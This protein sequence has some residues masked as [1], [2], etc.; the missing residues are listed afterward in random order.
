MG[1]ASGG[2]SGRLGAAARRVAAGRPAR[3]ASAGRIAAGRGPADE[4]DGVV[5]GDGA[6][7]LGQRRPGRAREASRWAPPGGV[8]TTTRLADG[9][10]GQSASS[11]AAGPSRAGRG[12]RGTARRRQ[13]RPVGERVDQRPSAART[14]R[15]PSS[16]RSRDS[17]AWVTTTPSSASS[18]ASSACERTAR[19]ARISPTRA[20]RA[21]LVSGAVG[22]RLQDELAGDGWR[23]DRL[24][25]RHAGR[26]Y[27]SCHPGEQVRHRRTA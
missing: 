5:A 12:V 6:G 2:R 24:G 27:R 22:R 14:L 8:R 18:W 21:V 13:G 9:S 19:A 26:P 25:G 17:V 7:D 11:S 4:Q 10:H 3:P 16:S 23:P 20:W 1:R 15:A